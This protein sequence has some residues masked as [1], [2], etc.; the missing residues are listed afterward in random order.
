MLRAE[1]RAAVEGY[2]DPAYAA[3]AQRYM[4]SAMPYLGVRMPDLRRAW[5]SVFAAHPLRDEA[6]LATALDVLWE[7]AEF[8]E[9]RYT[10]LAL[11]ER[12]PEWVTLR[13]SSAWSSKGRGG[14][15]STRSPARWEG[16]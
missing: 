14:T 2:R 8:R 10:A 11:V 4:T 16:S 7:R 5:R 13:S 6:E 12:H 15:T 1:I 9:E 3:G